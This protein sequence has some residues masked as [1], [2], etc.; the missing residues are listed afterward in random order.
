MKERLHSFIGVLRQ[1]GVRASVSES[2]DAFAAVSVSGIERNALRESLAATLVKDEAQRPVFDAVFARYF[3]LPEGA[4]RARR[5][6]QPAGEGE[7]KGKGGTGHGAGRSPAALHGA[8]RRDGERRRQAAGEDEEKRAAARL[9]RRRSLLAL[10]FQDMGARGV[11][12]VDDRVREL[13]EHIRRRGA[14]RRRRGGRDRLDMRRTIR[15]AVTR[16]GVPLELL[17]QCR[18][19]G[20]SD[21]LGLV[22][23]SYS[24]ATAADF[25]FA[26]LAPARCYFRRVTVLAYVDT[27]AEVSY[28]RGHVV[29]HAPLDLHARSDFGRVLQQVAARYEER[30]TR[31]GVL[32]VLGDARNNRRPPR[33]DLLARLRRR[34]RAVV[35]VSPGPPPPGNT[36]DR[37]IRTFAP[38]L[39]RLMPVFN[40]RTRAAALR[41]MATL[42]L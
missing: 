15:R 37:G 39:D 11:E 14:R 9:A 2:M 7:G 31:N 23:V 12:E 20:K 21:L 40:L 41:R 22:D 18:R 1:A 42:A 34:A 33:A 10:P 38:H 26:L 8:G 29:P 30:L 5:R 32:L 36:A 25:L 4:R 13:G 16:G 6:G 24:T 3:A 17:W 19:P 35:W 28:E 27:V